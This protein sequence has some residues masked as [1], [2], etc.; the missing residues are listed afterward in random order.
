M[1]QSQ[2]PHGASRPI[3][4][5]GVLRAASA[6]AVAGSA[7]ALLGGSPAAAALA[8]TGTAPVPPNAK[9][10]AIP[11]EGYLVEEIGENLYWLTDGLYQMMFLVTGDG[12]I[13]VD[14]PPTI[15]N[16][17]L[18]G[19]RRVTAQPVRHG[20]YSH[21]HADH[22]GAMVLYEGAELWAHR[23]VADIL[24]RANDPNRPVPQPGQTFD[25][26]RTIRLGT[27][28]L[29]LEYRG[30][31]HA[32]GN[33]FIWA[34]E[35]RALMLVDV[36]FPGWVPFAYLAVSSDVPGWISAHDKALEYPFET[37]IGGHLTRLGT[38]D[39]VHTQQQ[40]INELKQRTE[41][42]L[43]NV[44]FGA[45]YSTTDAENS[46]AIFSEYLDAVATQAAD[47]LTPRWVDRLGGADVFTHANAWAMA[48]SLRI[49]YGRLGP[50]GIR[51]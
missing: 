8:Q 47:Y 2:L 21:A 17:I 7:A 14:A 3:N 44:D 35:Q 16:N 26:E 43:S 33:L 18:R 10:P 49:D 36:I 46:W 25:R 31:N 30:P 22:V 4:R 40:Y 48:E 23:D 9:G 20:V 42:E 39:D 12:V 50:F 19:I 1:T 6:L 38:R 51:P 11:Q 29:K 28:Q 27:Q 45:I 41:R 15:G 24:S 32:P 13:A 5:R 34:P 37:L